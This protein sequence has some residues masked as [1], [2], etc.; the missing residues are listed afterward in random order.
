MFLFFPPA[1]APDSAAHANL[2]LLRRDCRNVLA[3]TCP[4][5]SQMSLSVIHHSPPKKGEE[6]QESL[7][8]SVVRYPSSPPL[9][10][11]HIQRV[12]SR[13]LGVNFRDHISAVKI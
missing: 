10:P 7:D 5:L 11:S 8:F 12:L 13:T 4:F 1:P 9:P 6:W 3:M 2:A